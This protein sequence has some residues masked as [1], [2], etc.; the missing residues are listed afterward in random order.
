MDSRRY[1]KRKIEYFERQGYL[2]S[3]VS[4]M[5][6]TFI[7]DLRVM[8]YEH[9]LEQPKHMVERNLI[10]KLAKNPELVN[11]LGNSS[12]PSSRKYKF[13][14]PPEENQDRETMIS[15]NLI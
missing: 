1:L 14:F 3:H 12:H 7:T 13:M 9:Y 2:F 8:T 11:I 4:E 6:I 15:G 10:E 5:N